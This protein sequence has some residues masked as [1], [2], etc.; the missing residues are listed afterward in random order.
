MNG[1]PIPEFHGPAFGFP[2]LIIVMM[3]GCFVALLCALPFWFICRKAG[4]SPWLALI[5]LVPFGS[6]VLPFVLAF[7]DWPAL[8]RGKDEGSL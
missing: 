5:T 1:S 6:L 8:R 2:E 4:L 3:I 7:I